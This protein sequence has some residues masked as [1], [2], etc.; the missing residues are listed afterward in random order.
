MA[1]MIPAQW[2]AAWAERW[3]SGPGLPSLL[4][5][6]LLPLGTLGFELVTGLCAGELFDPMPTLLHGVLV[7][8]VPACNFFVWSSFTRIETRPGL[9]A[10]ANGVA[11]AVAALYSLLFL[12]LLP[13]ATVGILY[14]GLGL[15]PWSP[16]LAL[17]AA[18]CL[19]AHLQR[20]VAE[21]QRPMAT[22]PGVLCGALALIAADLPHSLTSY[23]MSLATSASPKEQVTG[24]RLLRSVGDE[25]SMLRFCYVRT[26]RATD[27]LSFVMGTRNVSSFQA[28]DVY[29]RVTG[30]VFDTK[31]EPK[32]LHRRRWMDWDWDTD[33]GT[34]NVG[35]RL[36]G[37]SLASSRL[38]GSIDAKAALAYLEW[39]L[40]MRNDTP[41][42]QEARARVGLPPGAVVSRLTLW[43][44]GEEREAAFAGR[45]QVI[46]AYRSVVAR[47]RDPV[48][49]TTAGA[50]RIAVQMFP[51]P[52]NG[53][54]KVRI[55][56]TV[57][58]QLDDL[59]QGT[60]QLPYFHE[61]NFELAPRLEHSVWIEATS[62]LLA[63]SRHAATTPSGGYSL[64]LGLADS[65]LLKASAIITAPRDPSTMSWS[66]DPAAIGKVTQ[67]VLE[68]APASAPAR[69]AVVIDSSASM[70]A[71]AQS[72][73]EALSHLPPKLELY[74]I[75]SDD[76]TDAGA[77][78]SPTTPLD[79]AA[80]I[81]SHEFIGGQDNTAALAQALSKI[82]R[83]QL[84]ALVWIHGPQPVILQTSASIEQQLER[85]GQLPWYDVQVAP[86]ANR[87]AERLDGLA[88]IQTLSLSRLQTLF[89][90]W[91]TSGDNIIVH[92]DQLSGAQGAGLASEQTS[93][94]LARLW[95]HDEV[96]RLLYVERAPRQAIIDLAHDYRIVTPVTGAVVLETQQQYEAAGL[97]P[98]PEGT[99]P[100]IPEPEEW[101]LMIIAALILLYA[102][103]RHRLVTHVAI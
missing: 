83:T 60:L 98:V 38:D 84:G 5:G 35:S 12:P 11:I 63:G 97:T 100:S 14:F 77:A 41:I 95:A 54:M 65:E 43:V 21:A 88:N 24:I 3:R 59:R 46:E 61:R 78:I 44:N 71:S 7:A 30:E 16:A 62:P 69:L 76:L 87:T 19:R 94:H 72:I 91:H 32:N 82:L 4:F 75:F 101:A 18:L 42:Q 15:L 89:T 93:D 36:E 29:Y 6:V 102:W 103:R 79:A 9:L 96:R 56:M 53:E 31:P 90:R 50:D 28:R 70:A 37:L 23:G 57:P 2:L 67:Q 68:V 55:G 58:L 33:Q 27:M 51:V 1:T 40:V 48:L 52:P 25:D 74:L 80:S 20:E 47:R 86:G 49:V 92:R 64:E 26:G 99:V 73:A 66:H 13:V 10:F 85:R 45:G 34:P 22:W 39:T 81:R 8:L 17:I